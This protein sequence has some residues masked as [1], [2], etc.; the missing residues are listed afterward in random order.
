MAWEGL[1]EGTRAA[2]KYVH[3]FVPAAHRQERP[4]AAHGHLRSGVWGGRQAAAISHTQA[5]YHASGHR[6]DAQWDSAEACWQVVG[7][8]MQAR[9]LTCTHAA[10][11]GWFGLTCMS[12]KPRLGASPAWVRF[13]F[14][15]ALLPACTRPCRD[16]E[17]A[18]NRPA[19]THAMA[20]TQGSGL[21]ACIPGPTRVTDPRC[22]N[23]DPQHAG[24]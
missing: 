8:C 24:R 6:L 23:R 12:C 5:L 14:G 15:A 18:L 21:R 17:P 4:I 1:D 9:T 7:R 19:Q 11:A 22:E 3:L 10:I 13:E 2:V 16:G 20:L